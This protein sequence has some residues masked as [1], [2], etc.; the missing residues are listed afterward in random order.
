M[1]RLLWMGFIVLFSL[2][3]LV[4]PITARAEAQEQH[5]SQSQVTFEN[6][7]RRL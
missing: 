7:F 2:N 3:M 5:V 1:K 6:K 4:E